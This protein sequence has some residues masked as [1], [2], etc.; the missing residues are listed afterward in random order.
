M[1]LAC[2]I[3]GTKTLV[4]LFDP[5]PSTALG[6][7]P[8][9]PRPV[10]VATYATQ[11]FGSASEILDA[12]MRDAPRP[13]TVDAVAAG[14]AG[15][16]AGGRARLTNGAWDISAAELAARLNLGARRARVMNDLEA[17]GTSVE[18]LEA[19]EI[20]T[21]QAGIPDPDGH[22]VVIAAGTGLG[23]ATLHRV[24]G[25]LRAAASEGGHA[26]FAARTDREIALVRR[27]RE[28][29][30]RAEVEQVLSGPGLLN[31]HELTHGRIPCRVAADRSAAD[32]PAA[33]SR[34]ALEGTCPSCVEALGLFAEAY[35]AEAG[36]LALR[37]MATAG[38][39]IG[40]GIALKILPVLRDGR[41]MRAFRDKAPM[42]GLLAAMPVKVI[43]H[44]EAGLLGAAIAAQALLTIRDA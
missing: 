18:A 24:N 29:H 25:R 28:Q 1:L 38:V 21:L 2:D 14:V 27:L 32:A 30:G 44:A 5:G 39:Y 4:G 11:A 33:V 31:L 36:N 26:D 17:L 23:E 41:F 34:A 43:L 15:P 20:E 12:F 19:H 8:G 35:G 40:G 9:R 7:V 22:A 13:F 6:T 42:T 3:G 37:G 16:V 10:T